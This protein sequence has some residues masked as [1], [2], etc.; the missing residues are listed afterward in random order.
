[1]ALRIDGN[2]C[3]LNKKLWRLSIAAQPPSVFRLGNLLD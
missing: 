3:V 1:V 2:Q